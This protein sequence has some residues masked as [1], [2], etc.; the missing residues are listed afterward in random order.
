MVLDR[1][2]YEGGLTLPNAET[3][4]LASVLIFVGGVFF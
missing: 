3:R 4:E 2:V 1:T